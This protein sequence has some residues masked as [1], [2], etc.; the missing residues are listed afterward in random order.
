MVI[1]FIATKAV[2]EREA[3]GIVAQR[4]GH[5]LRPDPR[6]S[7][8][9]SSVGHLLPHGQRVSHGCHLG[10]TERVSDRRVPAVVGDMGVQVRS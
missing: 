9:E 7:T 2:I 3:P 4:H 6:Q 8:E 5:H 10:V 1:K